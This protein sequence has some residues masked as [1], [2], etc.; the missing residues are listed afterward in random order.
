MGKYIF[1]KER[2]KVSPGFRTV[3]KLM[4]NHRYE[5]IFLTIII[6]INVKM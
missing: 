2:I 5:L 3:F 6:N 1:A 4:I